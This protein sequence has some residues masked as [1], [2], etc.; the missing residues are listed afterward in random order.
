MDVAQ[1]GGIQGAGL[2]N[3]QGGHGRMIGVHRPLVRALG[4]LAV[5]R[6]LVAPDLIGKF[7][8]VRLEIKLNPANVW[9]MG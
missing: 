9:L 2:V 4:R 8:I 1:G 3:F 7:V 6:K 5:G